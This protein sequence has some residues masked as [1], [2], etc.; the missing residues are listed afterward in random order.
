MS[1]RRDFLTA[2]A[3][4]NYV[5]GLGRGATGF[6]T[7]SDLGPAREGPSEDAIKAAL[8]RR[9]AAQDPFRFSDFQDTNDT[10][11]D[12][13]DDRY[14]DPD[15]DYCLFA[16]APYDA[17]DEEADRIWAEV[18]QKMAQR[19]K[20][21]REA[22]ERK[23]AERLLME[24]TKVQD[25][26]ADV[27]QGLSAITDEEWLN[28]PNV[29]DL[30][31]KK[32]KKI[33]PR[34]RFYTIP[35]S[36]I[37]RASQV[38]LDTSIDVTETEADF[39]DGK[40]TN[41]AEIGAARDKVLGLKLDQISSDSVIGQSTIDPQGYLTSMN[42]M[43][44]KSNTELGD[45][46]RWMS[47]ARVE[48]IAGKLQQA[49]NI[50]AKGC[51]NCP[52]NEDI[53]IEA[54]GLNNTQTGKLII[55]E[56]V[57]HIPNSV[58]LWLQAIKLETDIESKKRVTRKGSIFVLKIFANLIEAIDI[59]PHS[60]KLWKEAV[61]LEE[62]PENAKILLARATELIP[63]S[64]ELWLALARLE[65]YEN[66]KKILNRAQNNIKTSYEIWIAAAR[67]EEQQGN[68][69]DR[70]IINACRRL[71]Q[72]G[73][74]LTREQWL[75]E[76]E[77]SEKDGGIKTAQAIIK[78]ILGQ[79]LDE[80]SKE[81]TWINDAQNAISHECFECAR[82]IY[83]YA[84]RTFPENELIW[85]KAISIEKSHGN[86]KSLQAILEKAV[87]AC[88]HAEVIWLMYAKEK[89][90]LGD[91]QGARDI[92]ER[93][94]SHNPNSEEIWLAAVKLE[95]N[96]NEND[97]ARALLKVARQEAG[98][99]RVWIKSIT[100][101]RQFNNID[102]ALQL[103]N[104]AL[105]LFPKYDKFWMIKGQ[106]YEDLGHVQQARETYQM[107]TKSVPKSVPLWILLSKLEES[108]DRIVIAR[109][110]LDRARLACPQ[111]PEL[112][113]E[114]VKLELR[115]NNINQAKSNMAK[116]LQECPTSGLVWSEAVWMEPRSQR[117]TRS[118]DA[119][120]KCEDDPYIL[121][122]VARMMWNERKISK[123]KIWFQRAI[124][125]NPD[126]GDTWAWYYKFSLQHEPVEAQLSLISECIAAEPSHGIVWPT[127][128][129]NI[130]N[131]RLS[132]EEILKKFKKYK[133]LDLSRT[134][135]MPFI[136]ICGDICSGK[137]TVAN[138]LV[139]KLNFSIL[140]LQNVDNNI[141]KSNDFTLDNDSKH[142]SK[143]EE[144]IFENA[145]Q[146]LNY[147]TNHWKERFVTID[148]F[149]EDILKTFS[150]RPFFLLISVNSPLM[151]RWN[152]YKQCCK[153]S[154]SSEVDLEQFV[155]Q[156]DSFFFNH[157]HGM[158]HL[159]D[160]AQIKIINDYNS[161]AEFYNVLQH[162]DLI[163]ENWFRPSWDTYF[164]HLASLAAL[165]SNCMKRRVGCVLVR[166]QRVISTGYNGTPR[167][168]VN[169]N[170]GGCK[171]CNEGQGNGHN[172]ESC[173]CLHAEE[174]ALLE[175]GKERI[176]NDSVLYCNTCP[177]LTCSVKIT[178]LGVREVVY[179]QSYS[180]DHKTSE[181]LSKYGV[182]LRQHNMSHILF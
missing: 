13:D 115:A 111:I 25:Q 30:T 27:I 42:S 107:G 6:T 150:K 158:V 98:T 67:L 177:C 170:Q 176:A 43:V 104:E 96:N 175:A 34:E 51:K 131:S 31:G 54:V 78:A 49:R 72:N 40:M 97:R 144:K 85:K 58:R 26:F 9:A 133:I 159:F 90:N 124:K 105:S 108:A 161:I 155:K 112:W 69:P 165:R 137:Q 160:K 24:K 60:V 12:D 4:E 126:I 166:N 109:G 114:S 146:M 135:S 52:T 38:E 102:N 8:A 151:L 142:L 64:T 180:M 110:I 162:I 113:V 14:Q 39:N 70:V 129:K 75:A 182:V 179:S 11:D 41:F 45:I 1:I 84:L 61:N 163:N 153:Y 68:D 20:S 139:E 122:T 149:N 106:I 95:Y 74:M 53:W 33:S 121:T 116:A 23:E 92:L 138:Y 88:P 117:K 36:L 141:V 16:G 19:R 99:E 80:E 143:K 123:A 130:Q 174:N 7:R 157:K 168:F 101:E 82:E 79:D 167:G 91:I 172:L 15:N 18:D 120:R 145:A 147:V 50:I 148:I 22:K 156:S 57:R 71:Q 10:K 28:I 59:I 55:A 128:S 171:R 21:R 140:K 62:D 32:R 77:K 169:C 152:R 65:T 81:S 178:Q 73:G 94:F 118:A 87:E 47:A 5:A 164:M 46:K 29:G 83:A 173:L 17:D 48:V 127:I 2:Q 89:K 125:S 93:S 3:P 35:D 134:Y 63:L 132:I 56:A 44:L 100:L 154:N 136:G 76:A 37:S 103:V 181:I 119:L 66:A 86:D